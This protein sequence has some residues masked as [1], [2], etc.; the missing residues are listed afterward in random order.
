MRPAIEIDPA[1]LALE[2][3]NHHDHGRQ[4][5]GLVRPHAR[6]HLRHPGRPAR[7]LIVLVRLALRLRALRRFITCLGGRL[8]FRQW[9]VAERAAVPILRRVV[10]PVAGEVER[11]LGPGFGQIVLGQ[12]AGLVERIWPL[13]GGGRLA[14]RWRDVLRVDGHRSDHQG[15]GCGRRHRDP[16]TAWFVSGLCHLNSLCFGPQKFGPPRPSSVPSARITRTS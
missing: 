13:R 3:L 12:G 4:L 16:R 7:A 8:Q 6:H 2:H 15:Q 5:D 10:H 14:L 1:D 11:R 9:Q